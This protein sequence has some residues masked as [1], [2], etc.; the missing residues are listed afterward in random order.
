MRHSRTEES[1]ARMDWEML[2]ELVPYIWAYRSRTIFALLLLIAAKVATVSVPMILKM[3]VDTLDASNGVV[4][5][6]PL[7]LLIGYGALR[8]TS[9]SF[10]EFRNVIFAKMRYGIMRKISIQVVEHL[11]EL[12]LRFHLDRKTGAITR[13]IGRGTSSI[14]NLLNYLLFRIVPTFIEIALVAGI[15][16]TN[17]SFWFAVVILVTF[18]LYVTFTLVVTEWRLKYRIA[19][20]KSE[21][22]ANS[23][24][25]DGL[26][27][28]ETVKY[29]G[30]EQF[31]VDRYDHNLTEWQDSAIKSQS[32]LSFLNVGQRAMIAVGVTI[33]MILAAQ[34]V[35][36]GEMTIGDL[37]AVNAYLLQV[38][39]PL[40]FLGTIYS[41]LKNA[42][43]DMERMFDLMEEQPDVVDADDARPLEIDRGE[44][45]F[46]GVEFGYNE[47]RQVLFGVDIHIR[48]GN[49]LAVVGASGAGKSTLAR[50]MYRFYDV[51]DGRITIDGQ[52]ISQVTQDS[53]RDAI[54][55]VPQD[56]VLFNDSIF[57]NIRYGNLDATTEQ[58]ERAAKMASIHDFI[59]SLPQGYDTQVGERGLKLSGGEKQRV[60]IARAILKDPEILIFD[61]ATSSLDSESEQAINE[62]LNDVSKD[63]TT[64]VIAHRLSTIVDADE[65]IVLDAGEVAE[66]G[67][68]S[69]LLER[70]G[71]YAY[72]WK[73]QQTEEGIDKDRLADAIDSKTL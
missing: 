43:S 16:L 50:L 1:S 29:F 22:E 19:M 40:G 31:E 14:S 9:S 61:E 45:R 28:Y 56:T 34:G 41:I 27:N 66:R 21:S 39:M 3:I 23:R 4:M 8:L 33:V 7:G 67:S 73:L 44:I 5:A 57:F 46:D 65:I 60:A 10:E 48:P 25:I 12:S 26:I 15:L 17:Y 62:A 47:D 70:D 32:S 63:R 58:I 35:V 54:G 18:S 71:L 20:N 11:H 51:W 53:L 49:K 72:M 13:D 6:L 64:L 37:V 38:F 42:F 30:N 59:V 69:E 55:I 52:D 36:D 2:R 24:A 68:H